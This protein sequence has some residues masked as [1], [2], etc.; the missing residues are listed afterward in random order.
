M[1]KSPCPL[2]IIGRTEQVGGFLT[3]SN[4]EIRKRFLTLSNTEIR[5]KHRGKETG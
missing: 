2:E 4:T 1:L 5:K 3:L